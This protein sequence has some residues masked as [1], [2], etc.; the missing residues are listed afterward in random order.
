MKY[1]A[2]G[3][4]YMNLMGFKTFEEEQRLRTLEL[5]EERGLR[6]EAERRHAAESHAL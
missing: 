3:T 1:L 4:L 6:E 2:K 5:G